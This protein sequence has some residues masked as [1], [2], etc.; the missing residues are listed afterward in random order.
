MKKTTTSALTEGEIAFLIFTL[1]CAG[2]AGGYLPMGLDQL[3]A[4]VMKVSPAD[5]NQFWPLLIT[6]VI[7]TTSISITL[8]RRYWFW[9][10]AAMFNFGFMFLLA[11]ALTSM[12][13]P[14]D[15]IKVV[16]I[17]YAASLIVPACIIVGRFLPKLQLSRPKPSHNLNRV[18]NITFR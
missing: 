16:A 2:L 4:L 11:V 5:S 3:A 1:A 7:A 14:K 15:P 8:A 10:Y 9:H 18:G 6:T 17:A 13:T 12:E